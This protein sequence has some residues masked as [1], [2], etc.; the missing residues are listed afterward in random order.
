M[1]FD[2]INIVVRDLDA[3]RVFF[4]LFGYRVRDEA[5]LS[6]E[7]I[8]RVVGLDGVEARYVQLESDQSTTLIELITYDQPPSS[9]TPVPDRANTIGYRHIAFAVA[10]IESEVNRL[11]SA[12]M[13]FLS[14]I[15]IYERTGKKIVYGRG[16]EGILV[17]LA[18]Y[19]E[20]VHE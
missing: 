14:P 6:G 12:G 7:W 3:A 19:P 2:H 13:E 9:P 10:D 5:E 1:K 17:E 20:S 16:P 11:Q 18:Q 4:G 8:S 15:H